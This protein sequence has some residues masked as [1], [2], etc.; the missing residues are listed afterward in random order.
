MIG[1]MLDFTHLQAAI[2]CLKY[3]LAKIPLSIFCKTVTTRGI[4]SS[5]LRSNPKIVSGD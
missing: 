4:V 2:N 1:K 5:R 3:L